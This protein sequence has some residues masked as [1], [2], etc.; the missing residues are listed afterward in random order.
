MAETKPGGAARYATTFRFQ[1]FVAP[2]LAV[3]APAAP[4][5]TPYNPA[6]PSRQ[7]R[8]SRNIHE[9]LQKSSSLGAA[10]PGGA[11]RAVARVEGAVLADARMEDVLAEGDECETLRC[12]YKDSWRDTQSNKA[13]AVVFQL[14]QQK[15][16]VH[17]HTRSA[18]SSWWSCGRAV[19]SSLKSC[20]GHSR[21]LRPNSLKSSG[22]GTLNLRTAAESQA[23]LKRQTNFPR[24]PKFATFPALCRRRKRVRLIEGAIA[25]EHEFL[26]GEIAVYIPSQSEC[27]PAAPCRRRRRGFAR[28]C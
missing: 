27:T 16:S 20:T 7:P 21:Q 6:E 24:E 5:R 12:R 25:L 14:L 11:R 3:S 28:L 13:N 2:P 18:S 8:R 9:Y 26:R 15:C 10:V 17:L 4:G 1:G 22:Y 19:M 23:A